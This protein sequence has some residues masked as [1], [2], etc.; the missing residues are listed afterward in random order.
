MSYDLKSI[1]KLICFA[2]VSQLA[3]PADVV[4]ASEEADPRQKRLSSIAAMLGER[5]LDCHDGPD[6][7]GGLDL[8]PVLR[9]ITEEKSISPKDLAIWEKIHDR[10]ELGEMPPDGSPL[11]GNNRSIYFN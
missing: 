8:T 1:A 6:S 11:L 9:H 7:A 5:C 4:F 2:V 10:V 3:S